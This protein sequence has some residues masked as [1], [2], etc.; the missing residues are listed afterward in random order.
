[1]AKEGAAEQPTSSRQPPSS[2]AAADGGPL[3]GQAEK[4]Y[5]HLFNFTNNKAGMD[6]VDREKANQTIYEMSKNSSYFKN[7]QRKD[8]NR[9]EDIDRMKAHLEAYRNS[10]PEM[11]LKAEQSVR[12]VL[13]RLEKERESKRGS[14]W[15]HVDMDMFYCAVEIRDDPS[16]KDK[17]VAVG[18]PGMICTANYVA[19][20]YGVRA[21]MPG[22]IGK[23][24]CADQGAELVFVGGNMQ[25]YQAESMT[26]RRVLSEFDPHLKMGSLDEAFLNLTDYLKENDL[27]SHEGR[28]KVA[29]EIREKIT[30]ATR[31]LT[32][33][34][35][36]AP[37]RMMAKIASDFNK[38]NGQTIIEERDAAGFMDSLSVRK[39]PGVG[40]VG[41]HKL[42]ALNIKTCRDILDNAVLITQACSDKSTQFLLRAAMGIDGEGRASERKSFSCERTFR[43]TQDRKFLEE[44]LRDIAESLAEDLKS[45]FMRSRH[46]TLKVKTADFKVKQL[47]MPLSRSTDEADDID[48]GAQRAFSKYI[49]T[50]GD[51]TKAPPAIRLLGIKCANLTHVFGGT[52]PDGEE[53]EAPKGTIDYFLQQQ[54][55]QKGGKGKASEVGDISIEI[56]DD[57]QMDQIDQMGDNA[58]A[59]AGDD[60]PGNQLL[61]PDI[62]D[63]EEWEEDVDVNHPQPQ[64]PSCSSSPC[65]PAP[66][67]AS[68]Q[69]S[70]PLPLPQ[71]RQLPQ[72][73]AAAQPKQPAPKRGKKGGKRNQDAAT[74]C[75]SGPMDAL[76]KRMADRKA[77]GG[78]GG[79][80]SAAGGGGVDGECIELD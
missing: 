32:A 36:I 26:V 73:S 3:Y 34:A 59:P 31:G 74:V 17:P 77:A 44:K 9:K 40:K 67:S 38:P 8:D 46:I 75:V 2:T 19:R 69:P 24:L 51:D 33:S 60:H 23:K 54:Q 6:K 55:K 61:L 30:E 58:D 63:L 53:R 52:G 66:S 41:E 71:K 15:C 13:Q 72:S 21:A 1:M 10:Q 28:V 35:G 4:D 70:L 18:G 11:R 50:H 47:A 62:I 37:G 64:P 57:E 79:G 65:Q 48:A 76:L 39:I 45:H 5:H 42:E 25:K 7:E 78:G 12:G 20:R 80:S 29:T 43:A 14:W 27:D 49:D 22:F 56:E 68:L 16:L